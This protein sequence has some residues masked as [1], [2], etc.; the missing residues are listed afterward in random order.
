MIK[1]C[2]WPHYLILLKF[3]RKGYDPI[4]LL[5]IE[6]LAA[7][8]RHSRPNSSTLTVKWSWMYLQA[9]LKLNLWNEIELIRFLIYFNI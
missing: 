7:L 5:D 3:M 6:V 1:T 9:S 2:G 8:I 4:N